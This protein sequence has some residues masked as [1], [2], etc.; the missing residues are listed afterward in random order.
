MPRSYTTISE[1]TLYDVAIQKFGIVDGLY[2]VLRALSQSEDINEI[3]P[4]GTQ[5]TLEDTE[6]N[7]GLLF[8]ANNLYFSTGKNTL[9]V[10][11]DAYSDDYSEAY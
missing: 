2:G 6:N 1:Q 9:Y 5:I 8:D 3:L 10:P 11:T 4:L 7:L